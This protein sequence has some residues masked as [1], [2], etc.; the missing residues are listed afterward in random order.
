MY[1]CNVLKLVLKLFAL[2]KPDPHPVYLFLRAIYIE[3]LISFVSRMY[4]NIWC[5]VFFFFF[6]V[7]KNIFK[8]MENDRNTLVKKRSGASICVKNAYSGRRVR[9]GRPRLGTRGGKHGSPSVQGNSPS[10]SEWLPLDMRTTPPA[11]MPAFRGFEESS[12]DGVVNFQILNFQIHTY[13]LSILSLFNLYKTLNGLIWILYSP[14]PSFL[15][16]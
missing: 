4:E 9:R 1:T 12:S 10:R 2:A 13:F 14:L 6:F 15:R 5:K 8:R 16:Y 7:Q 11:A 3:K